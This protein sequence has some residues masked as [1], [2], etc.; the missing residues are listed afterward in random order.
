VLCAVGDVVEDVVVHLS[1]P[2]NLGTDT[3]STVSRRRGGSAANVAYFAAAVDGRSRFV[4]RIGD[5]DTG[6][7]LIAALHR[8]GVETFV[9]REGV[10]GTIVV[11]VDERGE[12]TML[13]DRGAAPLLTH[14]PDAALDGSTVLHLPLYSLTHG[15]IAAASVDAAHRAHE[16]GVAVS[17]D[18]SSVTSIVDIG[19]D[20]VA[21]IITTIRPRWVLCNAEE[22]DAAGGLDALARVAPWVTIV[23]KH[24]ADPTTVARRD[25]AQW[26]TSQHPVAPVDDVV[27][28]TGAG[29]AFAAG[30][31]V[32]AGAG[33]ALDAC[34]DA[35][36]T[37]AARTLR[38]AGATLAS[39]TS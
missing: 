27:D 3:V 18:L 35:A 28:T 4:G 25:G 14:V 10:T 16:R 17:L 24:G 37:L 12:R 8:A 2:V 26:T 7:R 30:F 5:D 31:L 29:D 19:A 23:T 32:A 15:A 13:T 6:E 1:G 21:E 11:V 34:V 38:S 9:E 20:A 22:R 33:G 39:G 36:H